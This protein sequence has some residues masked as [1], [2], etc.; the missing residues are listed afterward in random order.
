RT[1]VAL[2]HSMSDTFAELTRPSIPV[3]IGLGIDSATLGGATIIGLRGDFRAEA[4]AWSI[5][6]LEFRAPG[7]TQVR[8]S[9]SLKLAAGSAEFTGPASID[10]ADPKT[11]I[12]WL[13][14][15]L[16]APRAT[17]GALRVR[18]DVTL[19]AQRIAVE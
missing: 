6:T 3:K 18:G 12:A 5:D 15:R 7:A 19:G 16:D 10:S 11:L 4:G 1:P 8:A 14:G 13:E 9:G 17:I 2:L